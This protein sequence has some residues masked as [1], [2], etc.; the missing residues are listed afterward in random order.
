M[1]TLT[2]GQGSGRPGEVVGIPVVLD[3][4]S[5]P[6]RALQVDLAYSTVHV[7]SVAVFR[8]P[9]IPIDWTF[10]SNT[11]QIGDTR[12]LSFGF[13]PGTPVTG[14]VAEVDFLILPTFPAGHFFIEVSREDVRDTDNLKLAVISED[15]GIDIVATLLE[16]R[17]LNRDEELQQKIESAIIIAADSIKDEDSMTTNHA[18]RL[19]WAKQAFDNPAGKVKGMLSAVL[20]ANNTATVANIQGATDSQIQTNVDAAVDIFADGT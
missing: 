15:G 17:T 11:P 2:V 8:G 4:Q 9:A 1:V 18:N 10:S 13:G 14:T 7:A 20:A 6:I 3:T 5:I 12:F 19:I 16:L